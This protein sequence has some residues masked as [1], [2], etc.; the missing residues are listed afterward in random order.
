MASKTTLNA[1]NLQTLGVE[2]LAALLMEISQGNAAMKRRL[3]ME[4]V[5]AESPA[6]LTKEIRKRLATIARTRTFVDWHD[7]KA[8][9]DDLEAQRRAIVEQVAKRSSRDAFDLMW[10]FLDLA[11]SVFERSDD[12]SGTIGGVFRAAVGD[13]GSISQ[14]ARPDPEQL[15]DQ[16]FSVL[17]QNG[18]GQYDH[19]IEVLQL[20]LGPAGLEHLKRRVIALSD[21]PDCRPVAKEREVV[22]WGSG[23]PLYA[24]E[25][26]ESSRV[27]ATRLALQHIAD[28]QGDVDGYI[29]QYDKQIGRCQGLRPR[30]QDGSLLQVEPPKRGRSSRQPSTEKLSGRILSGRTLGSK[31]WMPLDVAMKHR[32]LAG[33]ASSGHCP[34]DICVNI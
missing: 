25:I 29:A 7:R 18:Y 4:L 22:G 26:A 3:R 8:L 12:S 28:A 20:A 14:T 13:L 9:V 32:L 34:N 21:E 6:E 33:R 16:V 19:L 23:G 17:L 5:G 31:Y 1:T 2:R 24:D 30:S 15:A 10:Q 27:S 11:R